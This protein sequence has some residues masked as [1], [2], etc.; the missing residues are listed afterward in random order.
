M[1]A[2]RFGVPEDPATGSAHGPLGSYLYQHGRWKGEQMTSEQGIEL[3]RP[4]KITFD[5]VSKDKAIVDVQV[6]GN[7]V[8][9]GN[10]ILRIQDL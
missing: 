4:S 6:G 2:P 10:G 8:E 3:G 7:T 1:F 5:I 9:I